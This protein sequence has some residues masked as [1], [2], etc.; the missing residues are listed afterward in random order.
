MPA[1]QPGESSP[2]GGQFPC[3][4]DLRKS[5]NKASYFGQ[6][7]LDLSGDSLDIETQTDPNCYFTQDIAKYVQ[8]HFS[9]QQNVKN[10]DIWDLLDEHPIFPT[11]GYKNEIKKILVS[12]YGATKKR[13][14]MSFKD[15][16][17]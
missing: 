9:G 15:R 12:D 5:E 17:K 16:R 13:S 14:T 4:T 10:S 11:D 2:Y 6:T 3:K 7:V 8:K 1:G